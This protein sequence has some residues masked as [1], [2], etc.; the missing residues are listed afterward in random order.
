MGKVSPGYVY[1]Q[2]FFFLYNLQLVDGSKHIFNTDERTTSRTQFKT[3]SKNAHT[4]LRISHLTNIFPQDIK[5]FLNKQFI[6]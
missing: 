1:V 2:L 5:H 4:I 6:L 3:R